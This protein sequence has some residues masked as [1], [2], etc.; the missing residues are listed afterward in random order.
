MQGII[1]CGMQLPLGLDAIAVFRHDDD[2][3]DDIDEKSGKDDT[4][5]N[6]NDDDCMASNDS[7]V[8][9]GKIMRGLL[10]LRLNAVTCLVIIMVE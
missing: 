10:L 4:C 6:N 9:D 1:E 2:D 8:N 3:D 5:R 7:S